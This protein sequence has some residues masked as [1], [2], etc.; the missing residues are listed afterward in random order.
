VLATS[1]E[2]LGIPG[3]VIWSIPALDGPDPSHLPSDG[4]SR[5]AVVGQ[6][7]AARLFVERA[8]LVVPDFAVT[9]ENAA[10]LARICRRLDGMPLAIELAAA[11]VKLLSIDQIATR[12]D[13]CF[14]L[15]RTGHRTAHPRQR[16]LGATI[17]W[18]YELLPADE[19]ALF[20]RL[21]V[22]AGGFT[23]EAA[24]AVARLPDGGL[25]TRAPD[26]KPP[27]PVLDLLGH[28]V[29]KSLVVVEQARG[30][31][32]RY[33]LLETIRQYASD[34]LRT[35]GEATS[36]A[37]QHARCYLAL[38][39]EA[40]GWLWGV[41]ERG[42]WLDR[43][44]S[45]HDN[46]RVA[47]TW[48]LQE[49]GDGEIGLRLVGALWWFW[50]L[51]D[52]SSEGRASAEAALARPNAQDA[53]LA[54]A[55][56]LTSAGA[57]AWFQNDF[58]GG[59]ARLADALELWRGLGNNN[60]RATVLTL[61]SRCTHD[62]G[63]PDDAMPLAAESVN[64]FRMAGDSWGLAWGLNNLGYVSID[65]DDSSARGYLRE[66]YE[67]FRA[68]GD[69]WG[70][71]LA[72]SNLGYIA[73]RQGDYAQARRAL[74]DALA[75]FRAG[76][77]I[78]SAP[79]V[80]TLLGNI[81]RWQ[82]DY[83]AAATRYT[84]S[85]QLS[86]LRGDQVGLAVARI[87][88]ASVARDQGDLPRSGALF[89][90]SLAVFHGLDNRTGIS[91]CLAGLAGVAMSSGGASLATSLLAAAE[92]VG[93]D[94]RPPWWA[95]DR[96]EAERDLAS[97]R[98]LLEPEALATAYRIGMSF[99]LEQAVEAAYAIGRSALSPREPSALPA[100]SHPSPLTPRE[101]AVSALIGRGLSNRQIAETL[102]ISERT[103]DSHVSHI[104]AKLGFRSRSQIA[105]WAVD[106]E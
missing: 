22:F 1:R 67:R 60:G 41:A 104:L 52:H 100:G 53:S 85:A 80:L 15:L 44:A 72:A 70:G 21:S 62:L 106:R 74:E 51:R 71:A 86:R 20:R 3:E 99:T 58:S 37:I 12:L 88:L 13:D 7:E 76:N 105:V 24:E 45:D 30:G 65:R 34:K 26:T 63:N 61:L 23:L 16:T 42:R 38:A 103:A 39:E 49:G 84:D 17:E 32:A 59:R 40:E 46:L 48:S 66:S 68:M 50:I 54:R 96:A 79:R 8:G 4:D 25:S 28:L 78:W 101:L 18:S 5:V 31:A 6:S 102:Q 35:T 98:A 90:Q 81:V 64:A 75:I 97:A 73:Y 77:D 83:A 87:G 29:D 94:R 33:H 27:V 92:S 95:R 11:R 43:L 10:T 47:I 36:I 93:D 55:K 19:R 69:V 89:V 56:A 91:A 2:R 82:G 9:S 14:E 57:M